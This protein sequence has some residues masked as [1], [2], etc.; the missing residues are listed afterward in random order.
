LFTN[1]IKRDKI[2]K[3]RYK[4]MN[5]EEMDEFYSRLPKTAAMYR[6]NLIQ[7]YLKLYASAVGKYDFVS[8]AQRTDARIGLI[9]LD[10][11]DRINKV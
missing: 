11:I 8:M 9:L 6:E 5:K 1:Q 10:A 4:T 3:K 7:F 2:K